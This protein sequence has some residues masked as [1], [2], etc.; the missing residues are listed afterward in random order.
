MAIF[1]KAEN[2]THHDGMSSFSR[3]RNFRDF[4]F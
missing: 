4:R 1:K 3:R 2:S